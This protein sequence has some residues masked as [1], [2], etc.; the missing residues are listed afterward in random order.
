MAFPVKDLPQNFYRLFRNSFSVGGVA[1]MMTSTTTIMID[2]MR[3]V[4][5]KQTRGTS[6]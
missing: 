3:M 4:N 1:A 2:T 5:T 6:I